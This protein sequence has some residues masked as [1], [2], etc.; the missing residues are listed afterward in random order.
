MQYNGKYPVMTSEYESVTVPGMYYAGQL[1]H[2]KDHKRSA[3]GFIHGFRYTTRAVFRMLETKYHGGPWAA[4]TVHSGVQQ[5]DGGTGLG[6]FGCNAGDLL[7]MAPNGCTEPKQITT[8]FEGLLNQLFTRIDTAS[9]PYQMVAVLGDGVVFRC[10]G[11]GSDDN[12]GQTPTIEAEFLE[13]MSVEIPP[14]LAT[15]I[16]LENTDGGLSAPPCYLL[17]VLTRAML[18]PS[19]FQRPLDLFNEKYAQLPRL[20]WSFGYRQQRRSLWQA[21][22]YGADLLPTPNPIVVCIC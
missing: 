1:G 16:L 20:W 13:E 17:F 21:K 10:P 3:G 22:R 5:W 15:E 11:A 19:L 14:P 2:G 18:M 7:S 8:P 9:G 4:R 12:G 6:E